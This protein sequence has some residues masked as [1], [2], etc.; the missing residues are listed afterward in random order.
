[1]IDSFF[2]DVRYAVR[3]LVQRPLVTIVAAIVARL[4]PRAPRA[5]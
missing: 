1:M 5:S 4:V 3:S 2:K